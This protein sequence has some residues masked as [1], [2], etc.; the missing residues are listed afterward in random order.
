ME[1]EVTSRENVLNQCNKVT[2]TLLTPTIKIANHKT[3]S[4][5]KTKTT[6]IHNKTITKTDKIPLKIA[7]LDKHLQLTKTKL[8]LILTQP[9]LLF[10]LLHQIPNLKTKT[11]LW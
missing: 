9:E 10:Q 6:T 5:I 3:K 11:R 8:H 1:L 4:L 7:H 2:D